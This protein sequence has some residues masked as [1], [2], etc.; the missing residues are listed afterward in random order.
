MP[1]E[2]LTP[3]RRRE[4]TKTALIEAA[5]EVFARRGFAGASM[6]EIAETAGFTRGAI[7]FNFGS[8]EDLLLAVVDRYNSKVLGAFESVLDE[9]KTLP[10]EQRAAAAGQLWRQLISHDPTLLTLSL[11][12]RLYALRNEAFRAR[13]AEQQREQVD[14]ITRLIERERQTHN[15]R[16]TVEPRALAD[17]INATSI[18]LSEAA[19]VD[20]ENAAWYERLAEQFFVL[21]AAAV[22][23]PEDRSEI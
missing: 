10:P 15:L 1:V 23:E 16:L 8:K 22:F 17:I 21:I 2:K 6:E 7:Y 19:G 14:R 3:D 18:G 13:L 5:T 12:F 9:G 4:L 20:H 11:E